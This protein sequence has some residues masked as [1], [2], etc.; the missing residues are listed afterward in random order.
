MR[1]VRLLLRGHTRNMLKFEPIRICSCPV[2]IIKQ[3]GRDNH[4]GSVGLR[5]DQTHSSL[6]L[7]QHL[8]ASDSTRI[9]DIDS[10]L[11]L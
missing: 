6:R 10:H 7:L 9:A 1:V 2:T 3:T 8:I 11:P 4:E 5:Y